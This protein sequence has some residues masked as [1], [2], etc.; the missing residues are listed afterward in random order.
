MDRR[1]NSSFGLATKALALP[2]KHGELVHA[3]QDVSRLVFNVPGCMS[4]VV[5][6]VAGEPDAVF[7]TEFWDRQHSQQ[8]AF[9]VAGIYE[10]LV[11]FYALTRDIEQHELQPLAC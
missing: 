8:S 6:K 9:A 3:L 4:Y 2:G 7:I 10:V 5:S 1:M 11:R